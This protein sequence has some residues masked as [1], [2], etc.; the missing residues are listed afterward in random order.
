MLPL[1]PYI[2][3]CICIFTNLFYLANKMCLLPLDVDII[4]LRRNKSWEHQNVALSRKIIF[5]SANK[6]HEVGHKNV[7]HSLAKKFILAYLRNKLTIYVTKWSILLARWGIL[8]AHTCSKYILQHT[9]FSRKF[10]SCESLDFHWMG[11]WSHS[12]RGIVGLKVIL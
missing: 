5:V 8:H 11:Q 10:G 9:F 3:I 2:C 7:P 6:T 4:G 12:T 1:V